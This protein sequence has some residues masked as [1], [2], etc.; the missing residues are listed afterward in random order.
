MALDPVK[1][2]ANVQVEEKILGPISLRQI[3]LLMICG[4]FSY[5]LWSM[6]QKFNGAPLSMTQTALCWTPLVVGAAFAFIKINDVSLFRILLLGIEGMD[7]PNVR[8]FGPRT[9]ISITIHLDAP[10]IKKELP[11]KDFIDDQK[12]AK[13]TSRLDEGPQGPVA[14]AVE[15]EPV[16][17]LPSEWRV[18]EPDTHKDEPAADAAVMLDIVPPQHS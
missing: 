7:K 8:K 10:E 13:L 2:P 4:G 17:A 12:L 15:A 18:E 6:G 3:M 5:A 1:I 9:G 11:L 16:A 14:V